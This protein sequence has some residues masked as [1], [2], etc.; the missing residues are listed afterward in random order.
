MRIKPWVILGMVFI[1]FG[2]FSFVLNRF[3]I[4]T[5]L[6][7]IAPFNS[8]VY[9]IPLGGAIFF[10]IIF[11]SGNLLIKVLITLFTLICAYVFIFI[12]FFEDKD[13]SLIANNQ[14]IIEDHTLFFS[15]DRRV[16]IRN[17]L[18]YV[19]IFHCQYGDDYYCHYE[20]I[21]D[22]LIIEY[23]HYNQVQPFIKIIPLK[24]D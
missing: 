9:W 6:D 24:E 8:Y 18:F 17:T 14:F 20:I 10:V 22:Q 23:G 3:G 13:H 7:V 2:I 15:G 4:L 1:L 21:D 11:F 16:Y 19:E 5:V 12:V